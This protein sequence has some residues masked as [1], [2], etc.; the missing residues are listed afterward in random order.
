MRSLLA[1]A[2]ALRETAG[3]PHTGMCCVL[4]AVKAEM[5]FQHVRRLMILFVTQNKRYHS[6]RGRRNLST[7]GISTVC[8]GK[9]IWHLVK[10]SQMQNSQ[11]LNAYKIYLLS[12]FLFLV[13]IQNKPQNSQAKGTD[14]VNHVSVFFLSWK[15]I[16]HV[17]IL[18]RAFWFTA[19]SVYERI[20][21]SQLCPNCDTSLEIKNF[22]FWEILS[23]QSS[24]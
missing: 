4:V 9:I 17:T 15:K 20:L 2:V 21:H 1:W 7:D 3:T 12:I 11:H 8:H 6:I 16:M 18:Q 10:A 24:T 19:F 14:L 13:K 23:L 22:S 5:A